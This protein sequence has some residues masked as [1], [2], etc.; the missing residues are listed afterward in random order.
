MYLHTDTRFKNEICAVSLGDKGAAEL[1]R[2]N[3]ALSSKKYQIDRS[4]TPNVFLCSQ[5]MAQE[6]EANPLFCRSD[7]CQTDNLFIM[8]SVPILHNVT[9]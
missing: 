1:R 6:S 8:W 4:S 5:G 3:Y 9:V 2:P 7:G